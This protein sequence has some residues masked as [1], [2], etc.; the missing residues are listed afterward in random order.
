MTGTGRARPVPSSHGGIYV[1]RAPLVSLCAAAALAAAGLVPSATASTSEQESPRAAGRAPAPSRPQT[2][3]AARAERTLDSVQAALTGDAPQ[4]GPHAGLDD[5]RDL[6]LLLR[7]LRAQL[8]ALRGEDRARAQAYLARPTD[9]RHDRFQDGYGARGE[10][11]CGTG[12]PGEGT[13]FCIHWVASTDDAPSLVDLG[14]ANGIPDQVDRTRTTM[15]RVWAQEIDVAGYKEPLR[16]AGPPDAGPNRKIDL[17]LSNIGGKGLYGYCAGE[18]A[19]GDGNDLAAYCVLDDDYSSWEFPSNTPLENLQVT[20]AHEFFH[21]VQFGY[22]TF[23]DIWLLEG[24]ATWMEDEVYDGVDDNHFYLNYSPLTRPERSLD[25]GSGL[26]V[27]GA[28]LWWRYLSEQH[29]ADG[30]SG[31]PTIIRRIWEEA[32]DSDADRPGTYSLRAVRRV[33]ANRGSSLQEE[34][35]GFGL[36]NR[37]PRTSYEEGAAYAAAPVARSS[38]LSVGDPSRMERAARLDHLTTKTFAFTPGR[39]LARGGWQ[40]R[41]RVDAPAAKHRPFVQLTTRRTN[42]T[43]TTRRLTLD[44]RGIGRARVSFDSDDV[45]RV[46]LTLTNASHRFDC[47]EGTEFS[48]RGV[49]RSD[50]RPFAYTVRLRQ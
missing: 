25:Q 49:P 21:A 47:R 45:E 19:P 46:E 5:G 42:G 15:E 22:D 38:V 40:L 39:G 29:S 18:P 35:A 48:C 20:A 32:D 8:P 24:T 12:E 28:W 1:L 14:P 4:T 16:D 43:V 3:S 50:K 10:N 36:A 7:D 34:F 11:D 9:G 44:D 2:P 41:A 17:Y 27:Y 31:I 13:D 33:L 23:E 30:G 6:T 26:Y 37:A